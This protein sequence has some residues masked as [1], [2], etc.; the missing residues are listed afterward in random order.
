M[1]SGTASKGLLGIFFLT[2]TCVVFSHLESGGGSLDK[3]LDEEI[4]ETESLLGLERVYADETTYTYLLPDH[5]TPIQTEW[6]GGMEWRYEGQAEFSDTETNESGEAVETHLLDMV[7]R[8]PKLDPDAYY[9]VHETV[10]I[11][12]MGRIWSLVA[13]DS[14]E[15]DAVHLDDE[16][17][18]KAL[19]GN[20]EP[21]LDYVGDSG[22]QYASPDAAIEPYLSIDTSWTTVDCG[23]PDPEDNIIV[24]NSSESLAKRTAPIHSRERKVL[25]KASGSCSGTLITDNVVL[26][27]AHCLTNTVPPIA[28]PNPNATSWCTMEN[29]DENIVG[30]LTP[31]C[32]SSAAVVVFPSYYAT[33]TSVRAFDFA[34]VKLAGAPNVGIMPLSGASDSALQG[35]NHHVRGYLRRKR[36]CNDNTIT[37]DGLTTVD[38]FNGR[39]MWGAKGGVDSLEPGLAKFNISIGKG[40]SGGPYYYCPTGDCASVHYQTAV[41][42]GFSINA[43]IVGTCFSGSTQGPKVPDWRAWIISTAS[44]M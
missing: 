15:I 31:E 35:A 28:M 27:A 38:S 21:D 36:D 37:N 22:Y 5:D 16:K 11:D 26:T 6:H 40:L 41:I 9:G 44:A 29:L 18:L 30:G 8:D 12:N 34:L 17:N 19:L 4:S 14:D 32:F 39:H 10:K 3:P 33:G 1:N 20:E 24:D 25:W 23:S 42:S 13:L 43:C 2:S 7:Q